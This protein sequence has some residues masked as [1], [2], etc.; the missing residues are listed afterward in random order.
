[1]LHREYHAPVTHN[2]NLPPSSDVRTRRRVIVVRGWR[3]V[4]AVQHGASRRGCVTR[5]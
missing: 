4:F 1:M 5:T 2:D 3:M